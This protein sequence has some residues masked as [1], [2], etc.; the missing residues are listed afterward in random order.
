VTGT[1]NSHYPSDW[2]AIAAKDLS[3]VRRNLSEGDIEAAA[4]FLQ[5]ALEKHLKAFLLGHGWRLQRV[6]TLTILLDFAVER[7]PELESSRGLCERVTGYYFTER[8]PQL[9]PSGLTIE[10]IERDLAEAETFV[11]TLTRT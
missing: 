2:R 6:H 1:G 11:Q 3:R 10:D 8:Y 5:Q 9:L 4:F 7:L